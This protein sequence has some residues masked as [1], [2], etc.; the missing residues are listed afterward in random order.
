MA[1]KS[2]PLDNTSE[3]L[4]ESV[5]SGDVSSFKELFNLYYEDLVSYA[6]RYTQQLVVSEEIVQEVFISIWERRNEVNISTS[7]KA[8]LYR[9]VKNR[10]IS[11]LKNQ[12]PKE[13]STY[14]ISE[15]VEFIA[16]VEQEDSTENLKIALNKSIA[17]L[18]NKCRTI[19]LLSRNEGL[20]YK[21]IADELN[22]S[23]K[24]VE[25][26]IGIA[27]KKLRIELAP[28]IGMGILFIILNF[29][30]DFLGVFTF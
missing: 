30:S 25:N 29:I 16:K 6:H 27:I 18:P 12:L 28:H 23:V 2:F 15:R 11:Y 3:K 26:Q 5:L 13:Q 17:M 21:E 1:S 8:Y 10:T 14:G 9:A 22:L 4:W 24:T 7:I 19:F 20:T